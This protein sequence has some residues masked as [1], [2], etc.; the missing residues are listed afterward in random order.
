MRRAALVWLVAL[1][2]GQ[3]K[4]DAA[5]EPFCAG[6]KTLTDA[7]VTDFRDLTG[8]GADLVG[9]ENC[10]LS[11]AAGG[12]RRT[13][14]RWRFDYR[15]PAAAE[16]FTRMEGA[17]QACLPALTRSREPGVNHPDTF[18]QRRYGDGDIEVTLS[19]KDKVA[20]DTSFIFL[21]VGR[22]P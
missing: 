14:C 21:G 16:A 12:V 2:I 5:D 22:L 11:L 17:V 10:V 20:L 9:A 18:D 8:S 7:A 1:A 3:G 15:D 6:L 4:A 13:T 19:L